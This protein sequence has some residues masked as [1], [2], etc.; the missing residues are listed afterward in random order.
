MTIQKT[1][2]VEGFLRDILTQEFEGGF[3]RRLPYRMMFESPGRVVYFRNFNK[4]SDKL[5]YRVTEVPWRQLRQSNKA[6]TIC[7]TNP[8]ERTAYA[9]PVEDI[10]ARI[11]KTQWKRDYLE[12]NINHIASR[13]IELDWSI[14]RYLKSWKD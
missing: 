14:E 1:N 13:W 6:A 3:T 9:I 7:F 4:Q 8:A 5:W 10:E 2:D 11:D 12:V